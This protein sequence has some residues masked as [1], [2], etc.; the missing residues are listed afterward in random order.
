M[1]ENDISVE[2]VI[3]T[4]DQK[5]IGSSEFSAREAE[6]RSLWRESEE[7]DG[8]II[9][10][11]RSTGDKFQVTDDIEKA[12]AELLLLSVAKLA[13]GKSLVY[14]YWSGPKEVSFSRKDDEILADDGAAPP[15]SFPAVAFLAAVV[16]AARRWVQLQESIRGDLESDQ[17]QLAAYREA[18]EASQQQLSKE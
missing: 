8:S 5:P 1:T 2:I 12:A 9:F 10:Q 3:Y 6:L 14:T 15:V 16:D 7:V 17:E 11:K 18:L 4:R 13:E